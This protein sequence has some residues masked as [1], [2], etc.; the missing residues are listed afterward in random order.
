M[1]ATGSTRLTLME[2][3]ASVRHEEKINS[4]SATTLFGYSSA[5]MSLSIF[6]PL[7]PKKSSVCIQMTKNA[8]THTDV[9]VPPERVYAQTTAFPSPGSSQHHEA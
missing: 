6:V 7:Q 9:P 3:P 5:E 2:S 1:Q 8:T 4:R